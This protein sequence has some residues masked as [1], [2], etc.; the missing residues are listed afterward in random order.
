MTPH[1]ITTQADLKEHDG[2]W[3]ARV[4]LFVDSEA[5]VLISDPYPTNRAAQVAAI[6]LGLGVRRTIAA[7]APVGIQ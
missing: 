3:Y 2:L 1:L 4:L 6:S 7:G 5:H